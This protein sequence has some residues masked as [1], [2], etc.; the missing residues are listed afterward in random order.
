MSPVIEEPD[1]ATP[2]DP[3]EREGLKFKHVTTRGELDEL[4]QTNIES[5]LVWLSRRRKT[6]IL[7][8]QFVRE[9]HRRLFGE[10]WQWAGT[11][12]LMNIS[13]FFSHSLKPG[14]AGF[15]LP[16]T[17]LKRFVILKKGMLLDAG[18]ATGDGGIET[19]AFAGDCF[20][21]DEAVAEVAG[22]EPAQGSLDRLQPALVAAQGFQRHLLAL[23]RVH[24]GE[25]PDLALIEVHRPR[26]FI[27][28]PGQGSQ[29]LA[30]GQQALAVM[31]GFVF[32]HGE[33]IA[34][35]LLP[36]TAINGLLPLPSSPHCGGGERAAEIH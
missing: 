23:Q 6:D 27:Q 15:C 21:A 20:A 7:T 9:S 18:L 25:A 3:D 11:F 16:C 32:W 30:Q 33:I 4:E 24:A 2:L 13:P 28:L 8:E 26:L 1:G 36:G 14:T 31:F 34:R 22:F 12:R 29:F 35:S 17:G 19:Q 5:G 10:V